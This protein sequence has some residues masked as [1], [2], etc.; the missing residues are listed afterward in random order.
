MAQ[1]GERIQESYE[2]LKTINPKNEWTSVLFDITP[3]IK[4]E[5]SVKYDGVLDQL[6]IPIHNGIAKLLNTFGTI[7]ELNS[8]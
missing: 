6:V 5:I 7:K 3:D 2:E 8:T 1:Q 4:D